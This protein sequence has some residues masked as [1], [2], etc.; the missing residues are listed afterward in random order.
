LLRVVISTHSRYAIRLDL[1]IRCLLH[2]G[3]WSTV[4]ENCVL[5][6]LW[7]VGTVALLDVVIAVGCTLT[8]TLHVLGSR[9]YKVILR[10]SK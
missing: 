10:R 7:V 1:I 3:R 6:R 8:L 9:C 2:R 5:R 4:D